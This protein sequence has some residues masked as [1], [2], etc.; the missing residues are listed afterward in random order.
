[1]QCIASVKGIRVTAMAKSANALFFTFAGVLVQVS[2]LSFLSR[3]ALRLERGY[4]GRQEPSLGM[5]DVKVVDKKSLETSGTGE[6]C[7]CEVGKFWFP[8]LQKCMEQEEWGYECGFFP[9]D[10]QHRVCKDNLICK[11]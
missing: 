10:I 3:S 8:R 4:G 7:M 1:M 11:K 5:I 2:G 9:V 6:G